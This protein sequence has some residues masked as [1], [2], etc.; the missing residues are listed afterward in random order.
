MSSALAIASVTAVLKNLLDNGMVD[1]NPSEPVPVSVSPPDR[2]DTG[3]SEKAQLNLFLYSVAPNLGWRNVGLPSRDSRGQ[4]VDNPPLALDLYYLL[5]AYEKDDFD[6]EILLGYAMQILHETPLLDRAAIRTALSIDPAHGSTLPA[7]LRS[8]ATSN[9]AGQAEQI[10]ISPH[11]LDTEEMSKLW[12]AFQAKY[13]PS[14][15]YHVSVVLIEGTRSVRSALPVQARR[16]RV[17]PMD[18]P[19]IDEV[20]PQTLDAADTLTIVGR[21]LSGEQVSVS[22]GAIAVTPDQDRT[23][24]NRIQLE[25]PPG[26]RCGV[27]TVLVRHAIDMSPGMPSPAIR[28]GFTSN[29]GAFVLRPTLVATP[30]DTEEVSENGVLW[31]QGLLGCSFTP[32]VGR[33]QRVVLLLNQ[34]APN[35]RAFSFSAPPDNGITDP[36]AADTDLID[37][38]FRIPKTAEGEYLVRA[39]VDNAESSLTADAD[40]RYDGP[41]V[42]L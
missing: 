21:N 6:S 27:N 4:A 2:V 11:K 1:A 7:R 38:V 28:T 3:S 18:L 25:L 37:I 32:R 40:G 20:K 15:A 26:L 13:R 24:N 19:H 22:F 33:R 30:K 10:K 34:L 12:T 31:R 17:V 42:D 14:V 5:S 8:L 39:S 16:V 23:T 29:V 35:P 41:T 36:E 9:L